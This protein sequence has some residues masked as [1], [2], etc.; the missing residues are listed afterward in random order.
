M[1]IQRLKP[2]VFQRLPVCLMAYPD[3]NHPL[4]RKP[5][6]WRLLRSEEIGND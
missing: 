1:K 3:T 2:E 5:D 4:S 6:A